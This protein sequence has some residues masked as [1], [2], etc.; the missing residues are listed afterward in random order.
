MT[1]DPPRS[2]TPVSFEYRLQHAPVGV[3]NLD[4]SRR[5]VALNGL[6]LRLLGLDEAAAIGAD[7][8]DLHPPAARAKVRWLLDS[9]ETAA[10]GGAAMVVATP[11]G[12][13]V[14]KVTR[15]GG[16]G[17]CMMFH[18]L[19]EV[20]MVD[21]QADATRRHLLKLPVMR[22]GATVLVDIGE[23]VCLTAQGHY[24]EATTLTGSHLCSLSLAEFERRANPLVFA[25]VHRKHL[26]NLHHVLGAQRQDGAWRL[27]MAGDTACRITVGRDKVGLVRGLLAL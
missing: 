17:F 15:L 5:I 18:A 23:V 12:S 20:A 8:L 19:G 10:D 14:A 27:V 3:V 13:L 11:M 16:Q 9:A 25:R 21:G 6:A 2:Q 7:I 26:V 1:Q 4:R 24:S 22:G